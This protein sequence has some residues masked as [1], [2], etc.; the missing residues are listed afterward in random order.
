MKA[1]AKVA[2]MTLVELLVTTA[3]ATVV[4]AILVSLLHGVFVLSA[5]NSAINFSHQ[6]VR[7]MIHKVVDDI[8][9]S[10]SVPR[11]IDE[12]RIPLSSAEAQGPAAGVAY[13]SITG[14]PYRVW[15]N[16][17]ANTKNIRITNKPGDPSPLPGMRL[18]VPAFQIEADIAHVGGT[19][20]LPLVRDIHLTTNVGADI[21]CIAGEPVY[22][23]Y[24]TKRSGL[25]VVNGELRHFPDLSKPEYTVAARNLTTSKPFSVPNGNNRF[26][27]MEL[28]SQDPKSSRRGFKAV[29]TKITITVPFRN[30]L[31]TRQ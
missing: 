12:N 6:Q 13:Q 5:K 14:G 7:E 20:G 15:N 18:I 16:T 22:Q 11:L 28:V 10:A 25:V 21:A 17:Q 19:P 30:S 3:V 9:E 31:T 27:R 23:A 29:D 24:Y 4:G 2:G 26:V 8:R 1:R